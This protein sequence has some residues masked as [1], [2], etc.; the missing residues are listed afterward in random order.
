MVR[1][2]VDTERFCGCC[3]MRVGCICIAVCRAVMTTAASVALIF[4]YF[5]DEMRERVVEQLKLGSENGLI[6]LIIALIFFS[7]LTIRAVYWFIRGTTGVRLLNIIKR[8]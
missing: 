7:I 4:I 2:D 8:E 3:E 6:L 5:N 1:S